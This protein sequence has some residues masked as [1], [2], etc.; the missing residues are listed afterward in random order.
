MPVTMGRFNIANPD[1]DPATAFR[2]PRATS[3]HSNRL[4]ACQ[5]PLPPSRPHPTTSRC[6]CACCG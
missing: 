3:N 5:P 6:T 1:A 4:K 2:A